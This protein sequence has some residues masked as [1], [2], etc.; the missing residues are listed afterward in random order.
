M[1]PGPRLLLV[2]GFAIA[3]LTDF[4]GGASAAG[5][6]YVTRGQFIRDLDIALGLTAVYP[7]TP[8][9]SDV[10][11]SS[12]YYGYVEAAYEN[13][14]IAGYSTT[15]F[16]INGLL[17]REQVAKIEVTAL[18]DTSQALGQMSA[19]SR[20]TD[21][22]KISAFARGYVIE[23]TQ[24]GLVHGYPDGSFRPGAYVTTSDQTA[25]IHQLVVAIGGTTAPAHPAVIATIP[26]GKDPEGAAVDATTNRIYVANHGS[27]TVSVI[28]GATNKVIASI[29]V[30]YQPNGISVDPQT[31]TVY[32]TDVSTTD[33]SNSV[34]VINGANDTV[35]GSIT[36]PAT[37]YG[38]AVD[39]LT[40]TV[41]VASD[42]GTFIIDGANGTLS[43]TVAAVGHSV[44]VDPATDTIYVAGGLTGSASAIDGATDEIT[45]VKLDCTLAVT[46]D[47]SID[48][49]YMTSGYCGAD[50]EVDIVA[51]TSLA[52]IHVVD[53]GAGGAF[54]AVDDTTH[55]V[56]WTGQDNGMSPST[57]TVFSGST[58]LVAGT[59]TVGLDAMA[60]GVNPSTH[61][62]YA[63]NAD[64]DTV[65]VISGGA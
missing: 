39:S 65:S 13:G 3:M 2:L 62:A 19:R 52:I 40:D 23:A 7:P 21:D 15:V 36:I 31:D 9:F 64:S 30:G 14:F 43:A 63:V 22:A 16:G 42:Q 59:V 11:K 50:S 26:V 57:V 56:Y 24:L 25:F 44:A 12:P 60:I 48:H 28:D 10:P 20:F 34:S 37:G 8:T 29:L 51:G 54:I 35:S 45:T 4:G 46:V 27:D 18:G 1:R 49:V 38:V 55:V 33:G 53:I 41:Y 32:V 61:R 58:W 5:P 6:Q 17:T 47:S